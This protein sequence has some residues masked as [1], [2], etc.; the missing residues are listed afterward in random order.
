MQGS[1]D[2]MKH[3]LLER[4]I[5]LDAHDR[6]GLLAELRTLG[7]NPSID[8]TGLVRVRYDGDTAQ[9]L[10]GR[11]TTPLSVLRVREPSLEEA[12]V[13]LLRDSGEEAA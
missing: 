1:P 12:Y 11:I 5:V 10:I 9:P 2:D 13:E 8:P 3:R 4:S 6:A 7:L